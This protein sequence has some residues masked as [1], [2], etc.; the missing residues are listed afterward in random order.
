MLSPYG[1]FGAGSAASGEV[2]Y[3]EEDIREEVGVEV[4]PAPFLLGWLAADP[5]I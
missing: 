4:G 5:T 3:L 2:Q 1:E